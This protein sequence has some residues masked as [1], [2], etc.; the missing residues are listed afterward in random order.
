VSIKLIIFDLDE[1]IVK[2]EIP[3]SEMR[4][5]ILKEM[6]VEDAPKHLYE[7]LKARS[8]EYLKLLEREEIRRAKKARVVES[9]PYL[10]DYLEKKGIKLLV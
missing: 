7:F 1:T 5:R 2:N 9:L 10:L 6:G 8:K 4:E 3:F